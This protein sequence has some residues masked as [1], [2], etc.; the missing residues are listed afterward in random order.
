VGVYTVDV[1]GQI[2]EFNLHAV[3]LWGRRPKLGEKSERFCGS[4]KLYRSD[5]R[6]LPHDKCP[7]ANVVSGRVPEVQDAEIVIER[8]DGSRIAC[9][10]NI[11]PLRDEQGKITGAINCFYDITERKKAEAIRRRLAVLAAANKKA[12]REIARRRRV[13]ASLRESE[14]VQHVLL[15]ESRLLHLQM[16]H[17]TR[18]FI[19]AQEAERKKISRELHDDVMQTLVGINVALTT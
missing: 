12:H 13:E 14:Q 11:C 4:H 16:R 15:A 1:S 18:D 3:A 8:L 9:I 10:V 2:K 7:V 19:R 6:L 17:L 5:G